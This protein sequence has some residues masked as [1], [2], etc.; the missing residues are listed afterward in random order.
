MIHDLK[1]NKSQSIRAHSN[2]INAT[3][4]S[5]DG[6][7]LATFSCGENRLGFWQTSSGIFG[8]GA[9]QTR[10]IKTNNTT[11]VQDAAKYQPHKIGKLQWVS[12]KTVV[13]SLCNQQEA[14]FNI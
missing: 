8:I 10:C 11:P 12:N 7:I 6:K 13:L 1:Q 14:R 9:S 3:S 5:P 4:F 2:A